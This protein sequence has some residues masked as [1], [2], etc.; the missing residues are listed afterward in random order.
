MYRPLRR[1]ANSLT[2]GHGWGTQCL[3]E[4]LYTTSVLARVACQVL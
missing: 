4:R 1:D 2:Q 3:G